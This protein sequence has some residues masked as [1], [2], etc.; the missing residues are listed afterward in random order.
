[1][2]PFLCMK[3]QG[4]RRYTERLRMWK[5]VWLGAYRKRSG[6]GLTVEA[7]GDKDNGYLSNSP[8]EKGL[9]SRAAFILSTGKV[10][11]RSRVPNFHNPRVR[12]RDTLDSHVRRFG[13]SPTDEALHY[14][15][16]KFIYTS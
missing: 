10:C 12:G 1:M 4:I 6:S 14:Q 3:G 15:E 16:I 2:P 7:S 9:R 11:P 5:E 13:K 8:I